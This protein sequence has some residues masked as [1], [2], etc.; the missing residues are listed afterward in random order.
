MAKKL[1][2]GQNVEHDKHLYG[3]EEEKKTALKRLKKAYEEHRLKF[4]DYMLQTKYIEKYWLI[5]EKE[6]AQV[7]VIGTNT[8][9]IS[10]SQMQTMNEFSETE[11]PLDLSGAFGK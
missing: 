1:I 7:E 8:E 5:K 4:P 3:T 9:D 2:N 10:D 6:D 11:K